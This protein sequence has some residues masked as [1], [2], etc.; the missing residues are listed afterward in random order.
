MYFQQLAHEEANFARKRIDRAIA[1]ALER[2]LGDDSA[3][4]GRLLC[5]RLERSFARSQPVSAR[6][7]YRSNDLTRSGK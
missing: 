2:L 3:P 7:N 5:E 4:E 1:S 6:G